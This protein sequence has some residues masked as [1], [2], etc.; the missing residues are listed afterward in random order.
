M[1]CK[2]LDVLIAAASG[3]FSCLPFMA[4]ELTANDRRTCQ[5]RIR[6]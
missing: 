6:L 1:G 5:C 4:N 2:G 3:A